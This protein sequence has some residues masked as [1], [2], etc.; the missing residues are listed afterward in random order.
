M[1]VRISGAGLLAFVTLSALAAPALAV[2]TT[3]ITQVDF[4]GYGVIRS[5]FVECYYDYDLEDL[6]CPTIADFNLPSPGQKVVVSG[7][8]KPMYDSI[9]PQGDYV[10]YIEGNAFQF[11]ATP[12]NGTDSFYYARESWS[13]TISF[14][15]GRITAIT[16]NG[17]NN[18]DCGFDTYVGFAGSSMPWPG[19]FSSQHCAYIESV[20]PHYGVDGD[21]RMTAYSLNGGAWT[22]V[23]EPASWALLVAGFGLV[24][25]AL[26]RRRAPVAA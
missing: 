24:G 25:G 11:T 15:N 3:P 17:I 10:S 23:P 9:P 18:D 7:S 16:A 20:F 26:R 8:Y 12:T 22:V 19:R 2:T 14:H 13:S 4:K 1:T 21:W 5:S 6:V